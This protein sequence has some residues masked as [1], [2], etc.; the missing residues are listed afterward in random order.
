[1][2]QAT[3]IE[4]SQEG[5]DAYTHQHY[6]EHEHQCMSTEEECSA[7]KESGEGNEISIL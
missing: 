3:R 1:M 6:F 7:Q 5:D 4:W 2:R